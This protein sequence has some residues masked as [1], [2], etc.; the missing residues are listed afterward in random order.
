MSLTS[1]KIM[2]CA[3]AKAGQ[4]KI[5][6]IGVGVGVVIYSSAKKTAAGL[7][8][9]AAHASSSSPDNPAK[10]ADTA[11]PYVL[12]LLSKEGVNPPLSA[13]IVGGAVMSGMSS[14]SGMGSKVVNAV[15]DALRGAKLTIN[16]DETGGSKIRSILLDIETGEIVIQ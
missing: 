9:L 6:C 15:K 4:L 7:H 16:R 11:I 13:T 12:E 5:N 10:Y 1:V 3:V 8:I 2:Q 14:E